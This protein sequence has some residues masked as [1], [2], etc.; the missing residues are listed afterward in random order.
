MGEFLFISCSTATT[1]SQRKS[2]QSEGISGCHQNWGPPLKSSP[3]IPILGTTQNL[4][5][6]KS[7]KQMERVN[8]PNGAQMQ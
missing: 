6:T 8:L 7:S 4:N 5:Q 2:L 1:G 3:S